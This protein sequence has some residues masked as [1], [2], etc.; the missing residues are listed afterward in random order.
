MVGEGTH[1][2]LDQ[3]LNYS[4]SKHHQAHVGHCVP[5]RTLHHPSTFYLKDIKK[6]HKSCPSAQIKEERVDETT[7]TR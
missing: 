3:A 7:F 6:I 5:L 2:A 4:S 1:W